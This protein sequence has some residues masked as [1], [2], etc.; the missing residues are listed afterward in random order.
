MSLL[1]QRDEHEHTISVVVPVYRG[2]QTLEPLVEEMEPLTRG[3]RTPAGRSLRVAEVIL[4]HDG[5][6]DS[7]DV[8]IRK[9]AAANPWVRPVWLSRNFGQHAATIAG[10]SSTGSEWIATLDEDGQ[11]DPNDIG[12][13]LDVAME[14]RAQLVYASPRNSPPHGAVRNLGSNLTKSFATRLLAG[15]NLGR[16]SSF[17]L[18]LGDVGRGVTAFIGPGVYLD[19]ALSWAFG[20]TAVCPVMFRQQSDRPSGYSFRKLLSHFWQLVI[21]VGTRPLRLVSLAGVIAAFV[22]IVVAIVL[23]IG[24]L[25]GDITVP[26]WTSLTVIVLLLGGA[27]LF[28]LGVVAE[29]V[30]AAVSMAMGKP[31]YLITSDPSTSPL[32]C[33]SRSEIDPSSID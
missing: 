8:V 29:Y 21:T 20:N 24:K 28:A 22:G 4:V 16:F 17:R 15:G 32:D 2:E 31:L 10:M 12:S 3:I 30:G 33:D 14:H 1:D 7:S 5:G 23:L 11:F 9:L 18:M 26:G 19:V 6:P 27:N 13:L 25:L